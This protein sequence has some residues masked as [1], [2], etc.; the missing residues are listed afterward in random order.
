[1][2]AI[3][4]QSIHLNRPQVI[5][6]AVVSYRHDCAKDQ[7]RRVMVYHDAE[8]CRTF[9]VKHI[10]VVN[11]T[12]LFLSLLS[13]QCLS[14]WKLTSVFIDIYR[15]SAPEIHLNTG[16][17]SVDTQHVPWVNIKASGAQSKANMRSKL[18]NQKPLFAI[19]L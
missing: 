1:M 10:T 5:S 9:L 2:K 4:L 17:G 11:F 3:A 12:E 16:Y 14:T 15:L 13:G 7:Y 6:T 19:W 18:G 8:T